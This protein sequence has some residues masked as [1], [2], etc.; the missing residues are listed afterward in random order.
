MLAI[1]TKVKLCLL[2]NSKDCTFWML[3]QIGSNQFISAGTYNSGDLNAG[4]H[5]SGTGNSGNA[6][7]GASLNCSWCFDVFGFVG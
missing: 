4:N 2:T 6:N 3:G 5:N 1:T 7:N